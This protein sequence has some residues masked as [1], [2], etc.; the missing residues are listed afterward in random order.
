M[1]GL[2]RSLTLVCA[3]ALPHCG[4][5]PRPTHIVLVSIDT[6]NRSAL[7]AFDPSAAVHPELDRFAREAAVF[8]SAYS[9][10]PWTLP[11][12]A[13]LLTGLYPDRHGA[14]HTDHTIAEGVTRLAGELRRAGFETVAFSDG[15]NLD[16][17]FGFAEGFDRYDDW[18]RAGLRQRRIPR[19]GRRT[20]ISGAN[21]F[22]R[23]VAYVSD[24]RDDDPPF[25]L[26]L[27]TYAVH[28][29]YKLH[30][31]AVSTVGPA[32][33]IEYYLHCLQGKARCTG[34]DWKALSELYEA[35]LVNLD[36][37]LGRLLTAL[38]EKGLRQR[39][40]IMLLTDHGEGFD[41]DRGRIHHA[42]RLHEDLLRVPL[43]VSGPGVR[44][45]ATDYPVSLVDVMPTIL[46]FLDLAVPPG[47]DGE[48]FADV[49]RGRERARSR[50][51]YAMEHSYWWKSG[52]RHY[53][54]RIDPVPL[55]VAVIDAERWYIWG[56]DGEELYDMGTDPRQTE[57]LVQLSLEVEE[58]RAL[59]RKRDFRP[60]ASPRADSVELDDR[61]RS[62]GYV[63]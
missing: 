21:L 39:T 1:T 52:A 7:R 4:G 33:S 56:R 41:V 18:S 43:L 22:D 63:E 46:D 2:G 45:G 12:H 24:G 36:A 11:A 26:F 47:L 29:Y 15:G 34:E 8:T 44:A 54:P 17:E 38:D 48:S 53:R 37:G 10:A 57:N 42:G 61:L 6:L 25:F 60:A 13:S 50:P 59:A 16:R 5:P 55:S 32:R 23:A 9:T 27:H 49:L 40:L 58:L 20:P 31:W 51:L 19:D 3:V 14:V 28:D 62:L 30:P 35:E